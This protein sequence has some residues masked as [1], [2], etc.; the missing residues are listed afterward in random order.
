MTTSF[1]HPVSA[2]THD[3]STLAGNS[4]SAVLDVTTGEVVGLHFKGITLQA[5][6]AM[7]AGAPVKG[8]AEESFQ[9]PIIYDGL[10]AREGY[11]ADFLNL[12]GGA[13]VPMPVLT[14]KGEKAVARQS[15]GDVELKYHHFSLVMHK[16]R[17]LPVVWKDYQVS[18]QEIEDKLFGLVSLAWCKQRDAYED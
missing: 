11:K 12:P 8:T 17:R 6:G 14:T 9:I 13:Q 3:C 7:V 15:N 10:D 4:G 16:K 5:N 1:A 18:I 2:M